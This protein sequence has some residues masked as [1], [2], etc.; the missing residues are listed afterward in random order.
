M[1]K[2]NYEKNGYNR[3]E[4]N[5]FVQDVINETEAIITRC[6]LQAKEIEILKKEINRYRDLDISLNELIKKTEAN[7]VKAKD[8]AEVEA[9]QIILRAK[10][11]ANHIVNE[12]LIKAQSLENT[13][14]EL[15][16]N[17]KKLKLRIN[18]IIEEQKSI[19]ED[20]EYL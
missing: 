7:N 11:N 20:I 13:S 1:E 3:S 5:K 9:K 14:K 18:N 6:K 19:I 2:F 17:I 12:A 15:E 4:V 10:D 8:I 16:R